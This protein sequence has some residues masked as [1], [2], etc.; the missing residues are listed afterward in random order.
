MVV[1]ALS[2]SRPPKTQEQDTK[3]KKKRSANAVEVDA[4]QTQDLDSEF[5]NSIQASSILLSKQ[6][7][8]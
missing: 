3:Q 4:T 2:K 7:M 8:Q 1:D 6:Q 5:F